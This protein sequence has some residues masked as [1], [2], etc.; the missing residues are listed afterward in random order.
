[1]ILLLDY[2]HKLDNRLGR[3]KPKNKNKNNFTDVNK[4][5]FLFFFSISFLFYV[6]SVLIVCFF[7]EIASHEAQVIIKFTI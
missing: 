2:F 5:I 7:L 4:G 3:V 6:C 1:M